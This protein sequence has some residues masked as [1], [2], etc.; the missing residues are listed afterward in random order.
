M[1]GHDSAD[2]KA[3]E[4]C[5]NCKGDHSSF[6]RSCLT[7]ILKKEIT[8]VKIKN[9]FSY[10]EIRHVVS[11]RTPVSGKSYSSANSKT[12]TSTT[13]QWGAS[14]APISEKAESEK[15]KT[16]TVDIRDTVST[17]PNVKKNRKTSINGSGMQANNKGGQT[18]LRNP[19]T[20]EK[21]F[22]MH[23]SQCDESLMEDLSPRSSSSSSLRGASVKT[24][25]HLLFSGTAVV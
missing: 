1:V 2:C 19:M 7:W 14:T 25:C 9:K 18:S 22:K 12:Y 5:V 3:K 16:I 6:S 24:W 23:A 11:S 15:P 20:C 10:M 4:R 17:P 13:I 8:V 21:M